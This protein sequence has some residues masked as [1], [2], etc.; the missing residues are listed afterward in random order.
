VENRDVLV[1]LGLSEG[2]SAVYLALLRLG[3]SQVNKIKIHTKM[4]RTTIYDFLDSLAK[5]GL[6]SYVI[7]NNVK[8]FAAADPSHLDNL[9]KEK[10]EHLDEILP[11]L[12][13]LSQLEKKS[14]RVDVCDGTEGMKTLLN[15]MLQRKGEFLAFGIDERQWENMFPHLIKSYFKKEESLS[16]KE[17]LI[18]QKGIEFVYEKKN[19]AYRYIDKRFF[20]P[21]PT[22]IFDRCVAFVIWEPLTIIIIDNKDLADA[23]KKHFE[24]LWKIADRNP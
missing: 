14:I 20:S 22:A 3:E 21:I 15:R 7:R 5:K 12:L 18:T 4:H 11:T 8:F 2:E 6:V 9:V 13:R 23:Y 17:R 16:L 24:L 1:E 10:K 19:L